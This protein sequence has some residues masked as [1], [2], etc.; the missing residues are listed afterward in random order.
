MKIK[1]KAMLLLDKALA[2]RGI[3]P[4]AKP[5]VKTKI[6][7]PGVKS[8]EQK[9]LEDRQAEIRKEALEQK[10]VNKMHE[11]ELKRIEREKY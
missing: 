9:P 2:D 7:K 10:R 5:V 6:P 11:R 1:N 8:P 3:K 4:G